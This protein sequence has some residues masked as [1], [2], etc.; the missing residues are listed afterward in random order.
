[1]A[2]SFSRLI[3]SE[4]DSNTCKE[5]FDPV[6]RIHLQVERRGTA[7]CIGKINGYKLWLGF[8]KGVPAWDCSCYRDT[9]LKTKNPCIH[10]ITLAL[11]WDRSRNVPDP[12]QEDTAYLMRKH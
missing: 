5:A 6:K 3:I 8:L 4:E 9:Y 10:T 12:S 1:M 7:S 2:F 11:A